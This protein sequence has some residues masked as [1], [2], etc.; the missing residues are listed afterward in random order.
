MWGLIGAGGT[1]LI[2][3]MTHSFSRHAVSLCTLSPDEK[4]LNIQVYNMLGNPGMNFV[5]NVG[6][7]EIGKTYRNSYVPIRLKGMTTNILFSLTGKYLDRDKLYALLRHQETKVEDKDS[8]I[9]Y[10]KKSKEG[11]KK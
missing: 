9:S 4:S 7:V 11:H 5:A 3:Y 6:E 8:R 10:F 2:I 1:A